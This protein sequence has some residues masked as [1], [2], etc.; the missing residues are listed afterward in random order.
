[1]ENGDSLLMKAINNLPHADVEKIVP[2]MVDD[3]S[4][5]TKRQQA[6]MMYTSAPF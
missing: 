4:L 6:A 2:L 1:M 3:P 5:Y